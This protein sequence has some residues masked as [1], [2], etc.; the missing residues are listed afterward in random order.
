MATHSRILAWGKYHGQR[1]L[2][3]HSPWGHKESDMTWQLKQPI[4]TATQ[5]NDLGAP[6]FCPLSPLD[7]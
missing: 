2:V 4:N 6:L 1:S 7:H 5:S 3:G